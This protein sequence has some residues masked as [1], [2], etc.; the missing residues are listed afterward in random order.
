MYTYGTVSIKVLCAES[1]LGH[2]R[3]CMGAFGRNVGKLRTL[4]ITRGYGKCYISMLRA[5]VN[6]WWLYVAM[7]NT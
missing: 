4:L 1:L 6:L 2:M 5:Y 3:N 7:P